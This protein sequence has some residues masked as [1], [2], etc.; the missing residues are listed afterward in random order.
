MNSHNEYADPES[1]WALVPVKSL[2]WVKQRLSCFLGDDR[3]ELT[4]AMFKDVIA[5][6]K[7][8]SEVGKVAVVTADLDIIALAKKL[9]VFLIQ[10]TRSLGMNISLQNGIDVLREQGAEWVG[11]FPVDIP[12][13]TGAEIDR[14]IRAVNKERSNL[15]RKVMGITPCEKRDGTNFLY[16]N[17]A[18]AIG[19]KYGSN[20]FSLHQ[21]MARE[22]HLTPVIVDSNTLSIDLDEKSDIDEF[23]LHGIQN[24]TVQKT[25]TWGFLEKKGYIDRLQSMGHQDESFNKVSNNYELP[26]TEQVHHLAGNQSL[27][28]LC[29]LASDLRDKGHGNIVTY[30]KKVFIP[31][32]R[33]CRDVCHYCTFATTPKNVASPYLSVDE[34]LDI[35]RKGREMGCKEALFTLGE[36]PE[37]RYK[38]AREALDELGFSSTLEYLAHVAGIVLKETGLLPHINAGIMS[39][40]EL[41]MLKKVSASMGMMLESSSVR[42]C[43][44]GMVHYGS[45]DKDPV[46][47]L[48]SIENAGR[49]MVPFTTG[50]LIG[51]G[52]TRI[53]RLDSLLNLRRVH[54]EHGHIQEIIVQ[55]FVPKD[56]TKMAKVSPPDQDELLWT[57]AMTRIIFGPSMSIQAPPNLNSGKLVSLIGAGIND[58]G[59]VSPLTPDHVNPESP[60]P[61]LDSLANETQKAGKLLQERTTVY[62]SYI[63]KKGDWLDPVVRSH[64]LKLI[65]G[66][67]LGREDDWLSG[68]SVTVPQ[69]F[70]D[71]LC[72]DESINDLNL[73][74]A[75]AD[76]LAR[77][78]NT[79]STLSLDEI[80]ALF[81]ARG[82]D[83][84]AVCKTA[85]RVRHEVCG[86][87]VSYVVNRNINYTN[88][89]TYS[90]S[91]CAFSKG[92]KGTDFAEAPYLKSADQVAVLAKEAW[93]RGATEV[94][95]QGGIH[96]DFTGQTYLDIC[97]AV[98]DLVPEMHIHGFSP[99][100]VSHGAETLGVSVSNFL[101]QLKDAGL[102]TLPGTA[103]EI[104]R[105]EVRA[106][107][108]P[109][110]LNSEQWLS[111]IEEAHKLD[112]P[113]TATIMF[114]HVDTYHD[115]AIHL[116]KILKLQ[117]K[118][119]GLTEFVP[120]SFVAEEAPIYKR[121]LSRSGPTL[122]ES[123]LMH[124]VSRLVLHPHV[125][126]IQTSWVKMGL[127]GVNLCLHAGANDVGGTLMNE[128]ITRAA[129]AAHGQEMTPQTLEAVIVGCDRQPRVRR[130][131]YADARSHVVYLSDELRDIQL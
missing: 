3:S 73:T 95:L 31:L 76:I 7:S 22:Q 125:K 8:S 9:G 121:G 38:Q 12:L 23:V 46:L 39:P 86:D 99:L 21:E 94:C 105:D 75:I 40:D 16:F 97:R 115:W 26:S 44:K 57:I 15:G 127:E 20:S 109:D 33:L 32:T 50:I 84:V 67:G 34:V 45:P 106:L 79:Q 37:L 25:E 17:T 88:I 51:I 111:G 47:R 72:S 108:C 124:A 56:D 19:L 24:S 85:D 60:W 117:L 4:E 11:I 113:T 66:Y 89:C 54:Q 64:V 28:W 61:E 98:K 104:L 120:L 126:N 10:E 77:A 36:R 112:L 123:I 49:A 82:D 81:N 13:A 62:P 27:E 14:L 74:A 131:N 48:R 119:G 91:F 122:R 30:S 53:E 71:N 83:F 129:G 18:E 63:N 128:S 6:L 110:K 35:A 96:P 90:C 58:W 92:K 100:E 102:S 116:Q 80:A 69:S 103:A 55:N 1:V 93:D 78:T 2:S 29:D 101:G 118:T 5:A 59:G 43:Q 52:E 87:E 42:L 130:T 41:P 68:K 70:V 65:D 114:G 107:I